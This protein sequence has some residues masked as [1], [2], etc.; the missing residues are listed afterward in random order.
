MVREQVD[1]VISI[2]DFFSKPKHL[3]C[4]PHIAMEQ[5]NH[6]D[7]YIASVTFW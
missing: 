3:A 7:P 6:F 5:C 4:D 2:Q 1:H